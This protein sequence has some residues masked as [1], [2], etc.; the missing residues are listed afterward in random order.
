MGNPVDPK[1]EVNRPARTKCNAAD[2]PKGLKVCLD[3]CASKGPLHK[4]RDWSCSGVNVVPVI[5]PRTTA[6]MFHNFSICENI[7]RTM[8]SEEIAICNAKPAKGQPGWAAARV[9]QLP[10]GT[11]QPRQLIWLPS[12]SLVF[13]PSMLASQAKTPNQASVQRIDFQTMGGGVF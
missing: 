1:S 9:R 6:P 11:H 4:T 3:A 12:L 7:P 13:G 8:T 10:Q 5:N 2:K